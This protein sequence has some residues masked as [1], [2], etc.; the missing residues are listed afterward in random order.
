MSRKVS[1]AFIYIYI[2]IL[3]TLL[4]VEMHYS[5]R[6]YSS[7]MAAFKLSTNFD[8]QSYSISA[9]KLNLVW[10]NVLFC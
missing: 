10:A 8:K 3:N 5:Q 7:Y 4:N 9:V 1:V 2:W 6:K